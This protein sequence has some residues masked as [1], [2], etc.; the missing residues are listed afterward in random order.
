MGYMDKYKEFFGM[1]VEELMDEIIELRE[2]VE[3]ADY[4]IKELRGD[5]KCMED[6]I[7]YL[8]TRGCD[9]CE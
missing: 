9:C 8:E 7:H 2:K 1:S 3:D 6:T 5:I 4:K